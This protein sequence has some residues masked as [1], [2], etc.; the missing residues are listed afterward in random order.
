MSKSHKINMQDLNDVRGYYAIGFAVLLPTLFCSI[1]AYNHNNNAWGDMFVM[2]LSLSTGMIAIAKHKE[3]Q[4][5]KNQ[6]P[7]KFDLKRSNRIKLNAII[8]TSIMPIIF[9]LMVFGIGTILTMFEDYA[10]IS[11]ESSS[12]L[13]QRAIL[14]MSTEILSIIISYVIG[15]RFCRIAIDESSNEHFEIFGE[16]DYFPLRFFASKEKNEQNNS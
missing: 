15:M 14:G 12:D 16:K 10:N 5:M 3:T 1:I 6:L 8:G 4:I 7:E 11:P 13:L 9:L 2:L